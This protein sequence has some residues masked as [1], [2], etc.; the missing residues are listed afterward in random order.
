MAGLIALAIFVVFDTAVG[1]RLLRAAA[2]GGGAAAWT[3]GFGF[4]LIGLLAT[5]ST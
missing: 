3:C 1:L 4:T 2:R 5:P